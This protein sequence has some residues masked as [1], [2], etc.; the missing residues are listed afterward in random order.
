MTGALTVHFHPSS[1][2]TVQCVRHLP[3]QFS[4]LAPIL[5]LSPPVTKAPCLQIFLLGQCRCFRP[6]VIVRSFSTVR[7]FYGVISR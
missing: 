1:C 4:P 7:N 5:P 3:L 6:A 2:A